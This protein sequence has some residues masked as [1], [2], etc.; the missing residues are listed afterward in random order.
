MST[1]LAWNAIGFSLRVFLRP[2]FFLLG[3]WILGQAQDVLGIHLRRKSPKILGFVSPFWENNTL[4]SR[5]IWIHRELGEIIRVL[6]LSKWLD[7]EIMVLGSNQLLIRA[8]FSSAKAQSRRMTESVGAL[9]G[10]PAG[11]QQRDL[12]WPGTVSDGFGSF[13]GLANECIY[14]TT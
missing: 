7:L 13:T 11:D 5:R 1:Y 6:L 9:L 8:W 10:L 14:K 12:V 3:Q 4:N 2:R